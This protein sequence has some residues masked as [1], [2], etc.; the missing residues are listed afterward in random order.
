MDSANQNIAVFINI[1]A[2]VYMSER[3]I[4]L[5]LEDYPMTFYPHRI[6]AKLPRGAIWLNQAHDG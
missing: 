2:Q 6:I 1:E 4:L 3:L 5:S